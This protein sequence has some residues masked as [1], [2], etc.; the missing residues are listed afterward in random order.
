MWRARDPVRRRLRD[1]RRRPR[2]E[3]L[4]AAGSV[5]A[6]A[7]AAAPA[8]A[9]AAR[10]ER[11]APA[12]VSHSARVDAAVDAYHLIRDVAVAQHRESQ[13]GYLIGLA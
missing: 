1:V 7:G 10:Y 11:K 5:P 13:V 6:T 8:A 2:P 3:A 4:A 9:V 12:P